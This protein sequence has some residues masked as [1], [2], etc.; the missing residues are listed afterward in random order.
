MDAIFNFLPGWKRPITV[1]LAVVIYA[2][3]LAFTEGMIGMDVP[4]YVYMIA[5]LFGYNALS[6]GSK[7]DAVKAVESVAPKQS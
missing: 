6:Q 2:W 4:S 5:G 1:L 7:N 3:H